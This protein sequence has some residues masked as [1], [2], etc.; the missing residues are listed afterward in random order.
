[1]NYKETVDYLFA[2]LPMF[3][4]IGGAAYKDN[5][6]NI[7]SLCNSLQNPHTKFKSIHVAGTNGKGSTC[8]MLAS[9]LQEQG[10]TVGLFTSPHIFDFRERIKINGVLISEAFVVEFVANC[11]QIITE[12]QPSFF[13]LTTAMAFSYFAQEKVDV[14]VI[15]VG[16]GG[17]LD[18]TNIISPMLSIITN[19]G[20]DH[21]QFLG[22][23]LPKIAEQ[24]AGIIKKETPVVISS[25]QE[26]I[27]NTFTRIALNNNAPIF[28][29]DKIFD[30]VTIENN[31][32]KHTIK[33]VNRATL[34]IN[35]YELAL[36]GHYQVKN[37]K[38]VLMAITILNDIQFTVSQSAIAL[39]L[40]NIVKNTS[41][42]GRFEVLQE[43]PL[44]VADVAHNE[45]GIAQ[46]INQIQ[47]IS[48]NT[49]HIICGFVQDKDV[50][51]VLTHFPKKAIVYATQAQIPRAMPYQ[52]L[53]KLLQ[54]NN[55]TVKTFAHINNAYANAITNQQ[56]ND[57]VLI[58]G[59]FFIL[60]ELEVIA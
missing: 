18:S 50:A 7:K 60:G 33:A 31:F 40:A 2:Q 25:T 14:A 48:Y 6:D 55:F 21:T 9:I 19:I 15:E 39:G 59:S 8:H 52:E 16:M 54:D 10:Y 42:R 35:T 46:V 30:I 28:F 23:T 58:I 36:G 37:I 27:Q 32:I 11:Q 45:D 20:M 1:M 22:E 56:Q 26:E 13:E 3:T 53:G 51:K 38:G 44:I 41:L 17:L 43:Q 12:V 24:K 49:L 57:I 34:E 4:R 29:A 5:L 47:S